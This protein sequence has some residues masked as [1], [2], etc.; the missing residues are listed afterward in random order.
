MASSKVK[1]SDFHLN[2][3]ANFT[4]IKSKEVPE[5]KP[6]FVSRSGSKYW[7]DKKNKTVIRQSDHWG[8]T[9]ATCNWL[10]DSKADSGRTRQGIC[11]LSDF[12]KENL[13]S[14]KEGNT[15]KVV[16]T[17]F[18]R[19]G[20][21]KIYIQEQKGKFVKATSD[22]FIFDTFKVGYQTMGYV[23]KVKT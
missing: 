20:G 21:G 18:E 14:L 19:N 1:F 16:K 2:T 7:Y 8:R 17:V 4:A 11:K 10:I 23:E 15:Y 3:F 12:H 5:T 13:S 9:I 22:F 6:D